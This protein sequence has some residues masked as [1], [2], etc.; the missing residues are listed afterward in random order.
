MGPAALLRRVPAPIPAR[1]D[2]VR[3]VRRRRSAG[4]PPILRAEGAGPGPQSPPASKGPSGG[5]A[6]EPGA[7]PT[8]EAKARAKLLRSTLNYAEAYAEGKEVDEIVAEELGAGAGVEMSDIQREYKDKVA[9]KLQ[10]E[11]DALFAR[12]REALEDFELAKRCFER[13]RYSDARALMDRA[14]EA[15]DAGSYEEG[16]VLIWRA[17][18]LE[19]LG[20]VDECRQQYQALK[21]HACR[22]I[23]KQADELLFILDAPVMEIGEDERVTVPALELDSPKDYKW[24]ARGSGRPMRARKPRERTWEDDLADYEPPALT[25]NKY[26]LVASIVVAAATALGSAIFAHPH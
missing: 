2:G 15:L 25:E 5:G 11:A 24:A 20:L 4:A 6:P 8:A 18:T 14:A 17:M 9:A 10:A 16:D 12:Q 23:R 7:M 13:S 3:R 26:T 19:R 22:A 21:K 1:R